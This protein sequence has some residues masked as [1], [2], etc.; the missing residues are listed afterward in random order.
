MKAILP[1]LGLLRT[2]LLLIALL[3]LIPVYALGLHGFL[4][5]R[6]IEQANVQE[7]VIATAKLAAATQKYFIEKTRQ[8]L[9]TLTLKR[10]NF[11]VLG[12]DRPF[13][14]GNFANL[15]L[16][17]PDYVNFGLIER[18]GMMFCNALQ[19][20]RAVILADRSYFQQVSQQHR[21]SI[22]VLQP[23]PL[24]REP[25]L[26]FGYPVTDTNGGFE[27]VIFAS[28]K[29]S[30]LSDALAE[31]PLPAGGISLV[32]DSGGNILAASPDSE[33]KKWAGKNLF[34][35]PFVQKALEKKEGAFEDLGLDGISRI[36]AISPVSD[37][38]SPRL[39]A[40]VGVPREASLAHAN[41]ALIFNLIVMG[42]FAALALGVGWTLGQ[43]LFLQP[44]QAVVSAANRL[45][46]GDL[47]ART[48]INRG[49]GELDQLAQAF[50]SMAGS[51]ELRQKELEK[52]AVEI[53]QMNSDLEQ[54]VKE[55]T[56][57]LEILN[58]E[59]DA[60]SYTVSHDLRAPLRHLDAYAQILWDEAGPA[61]DESARKHLTRIMRA[62]KRMSALV[63]DLLGFARMRRQ[64][65]S[66]TDVDFNVLV[67]DI[68]AE[69]P[70]EPGRRIEWIVS[71]LPKARGDA[72]MLYQVWA[73]LISNAVKY[74]RRQETPRIEIGWREAPGGEWIFFVRDNG[75]GFDMKYYHKLFG[76]FH[77]L[78]DESEFEG[79]G[80]GLANVRRIVQRHSGRAWAEGEVGRG[81]VF[82]FSL[83]AHL[84]VNP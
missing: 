78:H 6:R 58:E 50:D 3:V 10:F 23:D 69:T 34:S 83:P 24:V 41:G 63:E 64:H 76:V 27:R 38:Y 62:G 53:K 35:T 8:L 28:L 54:R 81:A 12:T 47:S 66:E 31:I 44:I 36:Y 32:L 84:P 45:S 70:A 11:L 42:I 18:D 17:S 80:I 21:F 79:T 68:I 59:L 46:Q 4:Q 77:R 72:A 65:L 43:R 29:L 51:L 7:G 1:G 19:T 15:K 37:G 73:N 67:R 55:R 75:A 9:A 57:R 2:R 74:T 71:T 16:L 13:C 56:A 25:C 14:E 39:R 20:N 26:N 48:G 52:A 49:A 5:Q 22:G 33:R 61:L 60:F 30:R 40:V 82:Y